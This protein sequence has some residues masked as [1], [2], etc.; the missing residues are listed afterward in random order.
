M[1]KTRSYDN[2]RREAQAQ[3]TRDRIVDAAIRVLGSGNAAFT[4]P[5]I[6]KLSKVSAA[7][8]YRHFAD[9]AA[10]LAAARVAI[11]QRF[12][13]ELPNRPGLAGLIQVQKAN[14]LRA[15]RAPDSLMRALVVLASDQLTRDEISARHD[16]IAQVLDEDLSSLSEGETRRFAQ[17]MSIVFS[18][19]LPIFLW[20]SR[21]L[22]EDGAELV[23]W[24]ASTLVAGMKSKGEGDDN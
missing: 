22:N 18:S 12:G 23:E 16:W 15:G 1:K 14:I 3:E 7:T 5:Q 17:L 4:V 24:M 6:A 19:S 10:V 13:T 11:R 21:L 9:K 20:R 2:R 8:V